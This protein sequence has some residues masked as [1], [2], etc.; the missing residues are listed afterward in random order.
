MILHKDTE[1]NVGRGKFLPL[2]R[3]QFAS[4]P[5]QWPVINQAYVNIARIVVL[6]CTIWQ[7][8]IVASPI[9]P[10][11]CTHFIFHYFLTV[12]SLWKWSLFNGARCDKQKKPEWSELGE[13]FSFAVFQLKEFSQKWCDLVHPPSCLSLHL[14]LGLRLALQTFSWNVTQH[15]FQNERLKIVWLVKKLD[16]SDGHSHLL[17]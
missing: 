2:F 14:Y 11:L 8:I 16:N 3:L 6:I 1:A 12:L 7:G 13:P 9:M 5:V 4:L 15:P 10:H 17:A